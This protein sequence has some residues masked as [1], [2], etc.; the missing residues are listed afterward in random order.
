M[1]PAARPAGPIAVLA[2]GL[3]VAAGSSRLLRG[4]SIYLGLLT[5]AL[6]GP[7]VVSQLWVLSWSDSV[8]LL[9]QAA[10]DAANEAIGLSAILLAMALAG[11][12]AVS[13]EGG[14]IGVMLIAGRATGRAVTLRLA[15][16][17]SRRVFWRLVRAA[18][19]V[20]VIE[21]LA[22]LAWRIATGGP[23]ALDDFS[24]LGVEPIPGAIASA[25]F[26]Y[27][28]VAI[29]IADDGTRRALRRSVR[30][31]RER[32][33]LTAALAAFALLS[34]VLEGLA[35]GSG[36]DLIVRVT[37][38]LRL[39]VSTGGASLV[40]AMALALAIVTAAGSLV[41]TVAAL[42]SAPQIVAWHR[43]GLPTAGL[44][45]PVSDAAPPDTAP[46]DP[47]LV[48]TAPADAPEPGSDSAREPATLEAP[49]VPAEPGTGPP[50]GS[51]WG[52]PEAP[53]PSAWAIAAA[54]P[55][56]FHWVT[57]PMRL[58]I[59]GLWLTTVASMLS[60]PPI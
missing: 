36:L 23:G 40:L 45:T 47:A 44:P 33:R 42:V 1:I 43:L 57:I 53:A 49:P 52:F 29:V 8:D 56:R 26:I 27:S 4:P 58:A 32:P 17:R 25:P 51:G 35:L 46:P 39:D 12:L 11:V 41:F 30:L 20:G 37:E 6:A 18:L 3:A 60:R 38:A 55:P 2:D 7:G 10:I 13:I 21:V 59:V 5:L 15:V 50:A 28:S 31:A 54:V 34:G 22:G 14:A 9:S 16:E 19:A 48:D 24:N